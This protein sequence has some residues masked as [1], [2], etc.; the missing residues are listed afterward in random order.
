MEFLLSRALGLALI[1]GLLT[2]VALVCGTLFIMGL[3]I[4]VTSNQQWVVAGQQLLYRFVFFVLLYLVELN[5]YS[6]DAVLKRYR[7]GG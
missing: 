1:F 7:S 6:L 2:R 4:G 3:T 5:A